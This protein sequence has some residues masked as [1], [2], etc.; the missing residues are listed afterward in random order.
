MIRKENNKSPGWVIIVILILAGEM[1]FSLPFH[2]ARF[3]R[4]TLLEVFQ[5]NNTELGD[6]LAVY[7][8]FAMLAYFPG[9]PLADR[10]SARKL[11]AFSLITTGLGGLYLARIPSVEGLTILFG[12]WG[13]TTIFLFWA[14]LIKAT[15]DWGGKIRQGMAFG[16][17]DG[18]RGLVAAGVASVAVIM[19]SNALSGDIENISPQQRTNAFKS[20]I[21][22]YTA[23][24]IGTGILV[25]VFVP[26]SKIN[27]ESQG[28]SAWAGLRHIVMNRSVWLQA[29]VVVCAYCGYKGLDY[30]SLYGHQVLN[31]NEVE[32]ARFVSNASYL[33]VLGAI[34]AGLIAD[35]LGTA[36]VI[37]IIFLIAVFIYFFLSILIPGALQ[38]SIIL[39]NLIFTFVAVYAL[40]GVYFALLEEKK[41]PGKY[42]GTAVGVISFIGFTPDIFFN[43]I[44]GRILDASPGIEGFHNFFIL[45]AFFSLVGMLA[46]SWLS[47]GRRETGDGSWKLGA[48][49]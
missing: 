25:W 6:A 46:A 19:L 15:R 48:G 44:S 29:I 13:V 40:R 34:G 23:L 39:V 35:R 24:T 16:L 43:S 26:D 11:L 3:F 17:L 18:G 2:L 41:I 8:L 37:R 38:T 28:R 14:G 1:I 31:M 32:A 42:T 47:F 20:L 21:Y 12:Y 27:A 33:R 9:G 5:L 30:Y 49:S 4:P 45:M 10:F 22:L 7:G 36:K